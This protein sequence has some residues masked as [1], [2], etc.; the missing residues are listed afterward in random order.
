MAIFNG[1]LH[2]KWSFSIAMLVYQRVL[3]M[4]MNRINL[5]VQNPTHTNLHPLVV[6]AQFFADAWLSFRGAFF[7][8]LP[9]QEW[10]QFTLW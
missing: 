9:Y 5:G 6:P 4:K 1:K 7:S 3:V 2:Y 10:G 8:S